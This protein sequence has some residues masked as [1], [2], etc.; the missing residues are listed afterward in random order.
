[1]KKILL[2]III[3]FFSLVTEANSKDVNDLKSLKMQLDIKNKEIV[4]I[5]K[6]YEAFAYSQ[7]LKQMYEGM[8]VDPI[9]GGGKTEEIYRS[10]LIDE[11]GKEIVKNS[12]T[13]ISNNIINELKKSDSNYKK[14]KLM[15]EQ[16]ERSGE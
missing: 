7:W 3:F 8:P 5:A 11:Y 2:Q 4:K 9:Y 6:D 16:N 15:V 1:M 12:G 10:L 14:L 13:G